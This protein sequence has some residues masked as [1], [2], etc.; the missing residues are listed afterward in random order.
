MR[1]VG[2][3]RNLGNGEP[4]KAERVEAEPLPGE[5][6]RSKKTVQATEH[7][8]SDL[9]S[10]FFALG[11][12]P[13]ISDRKI[14]KRS[15]LEVSKDDNGLARLAEDILTDRDRRTTHFPG[16]L[17]SEPAWDMLLCLFIADA[18]N[19]C[20]SEADV[21]A[22]S[23]EPHSTAMRWINF[24]TSLGIIEHTQAS[25]NEQPRYIKITASGATQMRNY[26]KSILVQR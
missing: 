19:I 25:Q 4:A 7:G 16:E 5:G 22:A 26:L 13:T 12:Q 17:F 9:E 15:V 3:K 1:D 8:E 20:L 6:G 11:S 24:M 23:R 2:V 21:Y 10:E 18:R 14:A